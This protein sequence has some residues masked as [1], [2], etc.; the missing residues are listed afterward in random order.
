MNWVFHVKPPP[1]SSQSP[2][3][4]PSFVHHRIHLQPVSIFNRQK[5][6]SSGTFPNISA[7]E[8]FHTI[9]PLPRFSHGTIPTDIRRFSGTTLS[10]SLLPTEAAFRAIKQVQQPAKFFL[11]F[12]FLLPSVRVECHALIP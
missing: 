7:G 11:P 4:Q 3:F 8:A 12:V 2:A 10:L 1:A 6:L 9:K 5:G